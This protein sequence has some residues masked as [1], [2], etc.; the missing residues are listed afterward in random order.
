VSGLAPTSHFPE[1]EPATEKARALSVAFRSSN[2][3]FVHPCHPAAPIDR[4]IS[5]ET[6]QGMSVM[7]QFGSLGHGG[8]ESG[9]LY[10][11]HEIDIC[12][13]WMVFRRISTRFRGMAEIPQ[14]VADS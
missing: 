5:G 7:F 14:N 6:W 11:A 1:Q 2:V 13:I 10:T 8:D 9:Q 4:Q 12:L 3:Q